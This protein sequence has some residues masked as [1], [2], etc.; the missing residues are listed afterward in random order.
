MNQKRQFPPEF[1]KEAVALVTE[2][3]YTV[4]RTTASPGSSAKTLHTWVS[5]ARNQNEGVLCHDERAELKMLRKENK[6]LRLE[7][8]IL[9]LL[10]EAYVVRYRFIHENSERDEALA[11]VAAL[12]SELAVLREVVARLTA[13][14]EHLA[15]QLQDTKAELKEDREDGRQLQAELLAL[16]RQDG[17]VKR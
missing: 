8:E 14:G 12:E 3:G 2:Q 7:K 17:K 5:L 6:E 16:A 9:N 1:K 11:N 13:T 10:R 4:S 15:A